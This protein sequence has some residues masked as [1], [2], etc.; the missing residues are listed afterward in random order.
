MKVSIIMPVHN[1]EAYIQEAIDSI[2]N[3]T[4]DDLEL[5]VLDDKSTDHTVEMVKQIPDSR[6]RLVEMPLK[7]NVPMLRNAG[8]DLAQGDYIGYMDSDD[9]SEPKR[10]EWQ[11]EFLDNH[12]EYG[13]VGG[14]NRTFGSVESSMVYPTDH[15]LIVGALPLRC[16]LCNGNILIRRSIFDAGYRL[17]PDFFVCE[18]YDFWVRMIGVTRIANLDKVLL[19]IRYGAQQTTTSSWGDPVKLRMRETILKEIYRTALLN[20]GLNVT[21]EEIN[22]YSFHVSDTVRFHKITSDSVEQFAK[23]LEKCKE[24]LNKKHPEYLKGFSEEAARRLRKLNKRLSSQ[25]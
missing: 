3:Q 23:L 13:I 17:N 4:M 9:I 18:D 24:Q 22:L 2:L 16:T 8:I 20:V 7:T 11:C 25:S 14:F 6:I 21:D 5:I 19:N 15:D 1:R 12:S 10:L